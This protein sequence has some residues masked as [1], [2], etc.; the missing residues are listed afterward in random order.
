M[1][2]AKMVSARKGLG[3]PQPVEVR[4]MLAAQQA[5]VQAEENWLKSRREAL[6]AAARARQAAFDALSR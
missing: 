3:G 6:Q 5:A 2:P 1:D 4:R